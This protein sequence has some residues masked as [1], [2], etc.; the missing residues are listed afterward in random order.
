MRTVV[1]KKFALDTLSDL[2]KR[3]V[4]GRGGSERN[5]TVLRNQG[6]GGELN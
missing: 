1:L 3:K 5:E 2:G 6:V 4:I